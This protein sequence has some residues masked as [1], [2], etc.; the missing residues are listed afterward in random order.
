MSKINATTTAAPANSPSV[1]LLVAETAMKQ[2]MKKARTIAKGITIT[3]NEKTKVST[4]SYASNGEPLAF[5]SLTTIVVLTYAGTVTTA[6]MMPERMSALATPR[7]TAISAISQ[8][9]EAIE[10]V[11]EEVH[12][13][14]GGSSPVGAGTSRAR[15]QSEHETVAGAFAASQYGQMNQISWGWIMTGFLGESVPRPRPS[16]LI[17]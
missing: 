4:F 6:K 13:L 10:N 5:R 7:Q 14:F 16:D 11:R 15:P 8:R 1:K 9:I 2:L 17:I 12:R 3:T